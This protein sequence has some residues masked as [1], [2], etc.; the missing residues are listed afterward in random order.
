MY[1]DLEI[2]LVEVG[3]IVTMPGD[4]GDRSYCPTLTDSSTRPKTFSLK[5]SVQ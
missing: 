2:T 4:D 5:Q 1:P 3:E